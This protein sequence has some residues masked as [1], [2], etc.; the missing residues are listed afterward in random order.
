MLAAAAATSLAK[1]LIAGAAD[2][3]TGLE[4]GCMVKVRGGPQV[5]VVYPVALSLQNK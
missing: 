5:L 1:L 2:P 3:T 4:H